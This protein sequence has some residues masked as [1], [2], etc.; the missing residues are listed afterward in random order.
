MMRIQK[1]VLSIAGLCLAVAQ[2]AGITPARAAPV[3]F[4]KVC[5]QDGPGFFFIPGTDNCV[6]ADQIND[7]QAALAAFSTTAF[8]G[9]AISTAIVAPYMPSNSN[10]AIHSLGR[11][12]GRQ[13]GRAR[14]L[15]EGRQLEFLSLRR[16]WDWSHRRTER[17]ARRLHV[18]VVADPFADGQQR[19]LARRHKKREANASR[20]RSVS[21]GLRAKRCSC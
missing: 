4:V 9:V 3:Q 18:R 19:P 8:Q 21:L 6:D 7:T 15:D 5:N 20:S 13:R 12:R 14:R 1:T 16:I 10:Y 2:F 11:V 17:A